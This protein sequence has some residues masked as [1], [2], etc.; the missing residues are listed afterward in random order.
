MVLKNAE[1]SIPNTLKHKILGL[2][3]EDHMGKKQCKTLAGQ[4]VFWLNITTTL[5]NIAWNCEVCAKFKSSNT[6]QEVVVYDVPYI[7]C[8][9]LDCEIFE[10]RN[11][12]F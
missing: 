6:K 9:K 10:F 1:I 12:Q 11:K 3:D 2:L 8:F 7:L 5:L 4:A